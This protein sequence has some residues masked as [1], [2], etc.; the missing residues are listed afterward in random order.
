[1]FGCISR[2]IM[3]P[4]IIEIKREKYQWYYD[5]VTNK[6]EAEEKI[7]KKCGSQGN[8]HKNLFSSVN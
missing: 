5:N 1:M 7:Y 6:M 4:A 3:D 8:E 2:K